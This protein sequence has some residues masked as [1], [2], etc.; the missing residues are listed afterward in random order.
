VGGWLS[1]SENHRAKK[2]QVNLE[3]RDY[4]AIG[5]AALQ[6]F[7]LPI[8]LLGVVVFVFAILFGLFLAH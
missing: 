7:L 1:L 2:E 4:V 8:V 6:T 5:I 3:W